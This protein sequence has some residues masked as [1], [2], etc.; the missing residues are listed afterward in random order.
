MV[1]M[2][3]YSDYNT[4]APNAQAYEEKTPALPIDKLALFSIIEAR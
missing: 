4:I 1:N 2:I 3:R